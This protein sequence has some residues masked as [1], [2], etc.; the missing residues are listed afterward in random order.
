MPQGSLLPRLTI[1]ALSLWT[2]P[3][4]ARISAQGFHEEVVTSTVDQSILPRQLSLSS[5]RRYR[6]F[7]DGKL[8]K[9]DNDEDS[10]EKDLARAASIRRYRVFLDGKLSRAVND[11]DKVFDVGDDTLYDDP[12]CIEPE[13]STG[14][15]KRRNL[16]HRRNLGGKSGGK[17]SKS[18]ESDDYY[19]YQLAY[20][21]F[22]G[23]SQK[24]TKS[25]YYPAKSAKSKAGKGSK[26][27]D[28]STELPIATGTPSVRC[29]KSPTLKPSPNAVATDAPSEIDTSEVSNQDCLLTFYTQYLNNISFLTLIR[30]PCIADSTT[31]TWTFLG[32]HK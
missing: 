24:G 13:T 9:V 29:T 23:K 17:A 8:S 31:D 26:S 5:I 16:L 14:I 1:A 4:T 21:D 25:S 18:D 15:F 11:E 22:W 10:T 2:S 27:G 30:L 28:I 19:Y 3:V 12:D 32:T 7:Q 6:V 20:D